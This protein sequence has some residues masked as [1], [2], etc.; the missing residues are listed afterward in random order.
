MPAE[1]A[2]PASDRGTRL[3]VWI[4]GVTMGRLRAYAKLSGLFVPD[5]VQ[6][7]VEDAARNMTADTPAMFPGSR[8][9]AVARALWRLDNPEDDGFSAA[10]PNDWD[11]WPDS[12]YRASLAQVDHSRD[13]Y[14]E[15]A[16]VAIAA[17]EAS[18]A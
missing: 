13:D 5:L 16:R 9:E 8:V 4:D 2:P 3:S 14:R 7:A 12:G 6:R 1:T 17:L 15:Q 18:A 11:R 10:A